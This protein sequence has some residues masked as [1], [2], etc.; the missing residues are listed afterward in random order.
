VPAD[1]S[2]G[3]SARGQPPHRR[4]LAQLEAGTG[5]GKTVAYCLAA[6]VAAEFL[7]KTV[8]IFTATVALQEQLFQKDMPRL[9]EI[10]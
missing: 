4:N 7:Q 9:A 2:R 1:L 10:S 6:I 5:T 8:V 3:Q